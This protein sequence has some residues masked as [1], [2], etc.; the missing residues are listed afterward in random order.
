MPT[1]IFTLIIFQLLTIAGIC[2][3][4]NNQI[5]NRILLKL[6]EGWHTS[7]T[8]NSNVEWSCINKALTNKCLI[9]HNDQWF[10]IKPSGP[11]PYY[12]NVSKQNCSKLYG[13]QMVIIE[14]DPCKTVSY[15]L[16]KCIAFTDQ[17]DF[18]VRLD[19]IDPNQ[20]YLINIDGYLGDLCGFMIAF[21][22]SFQGIPVDAQNMKLS[23][24]PA[25][26][27]SILSLEWVIGDSLLFQLKEF[28]IY[29]KKEKEKSAIK[30]FIPMVH[31]AY[32]LAQKKYQISDTLR[33]E[34]QYIYSIYGRTTDDILLLSR[35]KITYSLKEKPRPPKNSRSFKREIEYF[36]KKDG[37]VS[38]SVLNSVTGEKLF[39]SNRRITKGKNT[40]KL[41]FSSLVEEGIFLYEVI[42]ENKDMRQEFPVRVDPSKSTK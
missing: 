31:N 41:D 32:G 12:L 40:L 1:K 3:V 4:I 15:R 36:V 16:K 10:S 17:S 29:R 25:Q 42:I 18:F 24:I 30:L 5:E 22:T 35:E 14:G 21:S 8:T 38:V 26:K 33:Q 34:G 23:T 28:Q 7:S 11:G 20:E 19:S 13:V 6:D 2:Q 37:Q 9:Y 27:D 39:S